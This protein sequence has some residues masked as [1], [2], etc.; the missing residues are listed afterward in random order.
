VLGSN[1]SRTSLSNDR[2]FFAADIGG[3]QGMYSTLFGALQPAILLGDA[4]DGST[5]VGINFTQTSLSGNQFV[6]AADLANGTHGVYVGTAVPEPTSLAL[7]AAAVVGFATSKRRRVPK[8]A[9]IP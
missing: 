8:Q 9:Q 5:V 7:C 4:L 2:V 1:F 6:F 3:H